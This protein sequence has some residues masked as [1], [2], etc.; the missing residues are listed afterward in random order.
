MTVLELAQQVGRDL[1]QLRVFLIKTAVITL[2]TLAVLLYASHLVDSF[3]EKQAKQLAFLE[4]GPNFWKDMERKLSDLCMRLM[5][6]ETRSMRLSKR[7]GIF[8]QN[9]DHM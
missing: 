8:R 3:I 2:A 4:G 1:A 9:T 7:C 6:R 5:C